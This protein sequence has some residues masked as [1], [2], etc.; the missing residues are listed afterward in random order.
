M[1]LRP[2]NVLSICTGVGGLDRGLDEALRGVGFAAR[3]VCYIEREA[4]AVAC[5][6]ARIQEGALGAAPVW[7]DVSTFDTR[8]WRGVVDCIVGGYPCQD[9][10]T[11]GKQRGVEGERWIWPH[12]QSH[13]LDLQPALVCFENVANHLSIGGRE[14]VRDLQEMDYRVAATLLR[15]SDVG[16]PHKRERLFIVGARRTPGEFFDVD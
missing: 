16:A 13:I 7:S 8:P 11:A 2:I 1:A 12:I 6:V 3:P 4:F 14:V 15:A 10:S 5:L 9:F